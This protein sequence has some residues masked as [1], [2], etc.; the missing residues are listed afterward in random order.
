[1]IGQPFRLMPWQREFLN[2]LYDCDEN[3]NLSYR[4]AL[5]GVP[6]GNGKSPLVACDA[7]YHLLGDA[8][9]PD[10]WVVCSAASD[11]QADI[12][13]GAAKTICELSPRLNAATERYRWEIRPKGA[14]GKI[15]RVAASNGKLDGK[16]ISKLY[17]DELH[18]W[19]LEN[20]VVLQGGAGKRR[21]SQVVQT[22]TAGFDKESVC[23][24][25][26]DKGLRIQAGKSEI[27]NYLFRWYGA[28]D[29]ADYRDYEVWRAANP[30]FD[31]IINEEQLAD[32]C[33]NIPESQFRRYHMNQ[34]VEAEEL[35][36]PPG[37]WDACKVADFEL[38]AGYPTFVGVDASTKHDSTAVVVG[39]WRGERLYVKAK[40]WERDLDPNGNPVEGWSIPFIEVE[41]YI[42]ELWRTYKAREIAYD[43]AF[44][45]W[46]AQGLTNEGAPMVEFYQTDIRM[47][48][49]TQVTYDAILNKRFAHDGDPVLA[50]H[51]RSAMAVQTNRGGQRLTKGKQ[52]RIHNMIDGAVGLVMMGDRAMHFQKQPDVVP[53]GNEVYEDDRGPEFSGIRGKTF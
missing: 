23:Y 30:S 20:W 3:G 47:V 34:W 10:P 24:R 16:I 12:V 36:L 41:Q 15:E 45:T 31:V 13:F 35:W 11:K 44:I 6:K 42:R 39:Q 7:L 17:M 2:D 29:G 38:E 27:K 26:Y 8:N 43:P 32:R 48:P 21:R 19:T 22:T 33:A 9:E 5:L 14:P 53:I 51:I 37:A 4:W 50:R 18:E 1:M 28:P 25:E 49:A 52:R 40:I 46:M